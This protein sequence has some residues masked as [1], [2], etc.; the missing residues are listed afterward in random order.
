MAGGNPE[1]HPGGAKRPAPL[2]QL[3]PLDAHGHARGGQH[4][5]RDGPRHLGGQRRERVPRGGRRGGTSVRGRARY[6]DDGET[7]GMSGILR[8]LAVAC[9]ML[10][11]LAPAATAQ[12]SPA[13]PLQQA[14]GSPLTPFRPQPAPAPPVTTPT[15]TT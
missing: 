14:P 10:L 8:Y 3:R 6:S 9:A 1:S 5:R 15:V 7:A 4:P 13:S 12:S 11:L 2:Q